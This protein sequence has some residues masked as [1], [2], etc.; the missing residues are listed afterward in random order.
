MRIA[1]RA[2]ASVHIGSGHI[3]RCATLAGALRRSGAEILFVCRALPG[4]LVSWLEQSDFRV[5][6]LE[7]VGDDIDQTAAVLAAEG[8]FDWLIVDHY[9]LDSTWELAM[10]RYC[11]RILVIDDKADRRHE[12]DLLLD[13]NLIASQAARYGEKI[14][15]ESGRLFGPSYALLQAEYAALHPKVSF[16]SGNIRRLLVFFG[17]ADEHNLT[18]MALDA[19]RH[20]GRDDLQIHVVI[21]SANPNRPSIL[22]LAA[23]MPSV[24]IHEAVPSL[25]PLM[26]AADLA[27]GSGGATSWERCCMG[28]PALIVTQADNQVPIARALH[29]R[30]LAIWL[31]DVSEISCES[32]ASEISRLVD[33]GLEQIWSAS[34]HAICDGKGAERVAS[35]LY[36]GSQSELKVQRV[37]LEEISAMSN[38]GVDDADAIV[39]ALDAGHDGDWFCVVDNKSEVPLFIAHSISRENA[40][41]LSIVKTPM[42]GTLITTAD[43]AKAI[44]NNMKNEMAVVNVKPY[45]ITGLRIAVCSGAGNWVRPFVPAMMVDW[46]AQGHHVSWAERAEQLAPADIC[47]YLGYGSIVGAELLSRHRHNLVVHA[48]DLPTGRGWS[49]MSWLILEG[50]ARI[51]V[52]LFEAAVAVDSGQI[53]LQRSMECDGSEL[54]EELRA[55]LAGVTVDLCREFV[56]SY[57]DIVQCARPQQGVPTYYPRRSAADSRLDPDRTISEQF[58]LLRIVDNDNYPAW[59]E[60]R[61]HRYV[62]KIEKSG[63]ADT[64]KEGK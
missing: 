41:E 37:S 35:L 11:R 14:P 2:D 21:G 10:R 5:I 20:V 36:S 26:I 15:P 12:C 61:G 57:P 24:V 47:F 38:W 43:A 44:L 53:Y 39:G 59:F 1:F 6:T 58:D 22:T 30:G 23:S 4:N 51:P 55:R 49:P 64:A 32:L 25:A 31:G 27:L 45:K 16:R 9:E 28:L 48:S 60:F 34:C 13:Q 46:L 52:S 7:P 56:A 3:V 17:G 33:R 42:V 62:I 8:R 19:L 29:E 54:V 40:S 50:A 18:G 63:H